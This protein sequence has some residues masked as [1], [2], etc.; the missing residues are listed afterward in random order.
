M[1]PKTEIINKIKEYENKLPLH[2]KYWRY[3]KSYTVKN[4]LVCITYNTTHYCFLEYYKPLSY[5]PN[6]TE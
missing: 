5:V 2:A 3:E 4:E 6:I 1:Q